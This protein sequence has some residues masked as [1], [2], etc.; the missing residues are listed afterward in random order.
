MNFIE[1]SQ[2]GSVSIAA[3]DV[4]EAKLALKEL[5]FQK[6]ALNTQK[7]EINEQIRQI[8]VSYTAHTR[9]RGSRF[10][11]GGWLGRIVRAGQ[12]VSRDNDRSELANMIAPYEQKKQW[13]ESASIRIDKAVLQVE[14]YI[15]ENS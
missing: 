8:R 1:I 7:K 3:K 11:G 13:L 12:T 9:H 2:D 4:G 15:H 14:F 6:K 10:I 5:K